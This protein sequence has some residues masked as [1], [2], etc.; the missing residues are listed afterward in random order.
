MLTRIRYTNEHFF[1]PNSK[2]TKAHFLMQKRH[3][4]GPRL[5]TL[6]FNLEKYFEMH[7]T[8]NKI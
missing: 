3:Y 8:E 4:L 1:V 5:E 6:V 2:L 7:V